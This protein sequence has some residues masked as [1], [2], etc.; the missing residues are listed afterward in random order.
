MCKYFFTSKS[1]FFLLHLLT[2]TSTAQRQTQNSFR[3]RFGPN[4]LVGY[5]SYVPVDYNS[6]PSKKFPLLLFLHGS[7]EKAYNPQDLSNLYL[8]KK[9]GPPM[10]IENGQDFPFI[11]ISPQCP[12]GDWN[13][14]NPDN[15]QTSQ[16][17]PGEF[18]DEILEKIKTLYR[19]DLDRI[20][21]TGLSIGGAATWE[22]TQRHPEKIAASI[23]LLAGEMVPNL[24][25]LQLIMFQYGH[26]K[27][28]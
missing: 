4:Y 1:F 16:S 13:F 10:L 11:V 7:G 27:G 23:Q 6:N 2:L 3:S 12:F 5:L 8:V 15:S 9:N 18:V 19:V 28:N 22:Y 24:V 21:I 26:F 20:Y 17:K 14:I 25:V